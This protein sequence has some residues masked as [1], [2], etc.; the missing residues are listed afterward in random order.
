MIAMQKQLPLNVLHTFDNESMAQSWLF[1]HGLV[2]VIGD[3]VLDVFGARYAFAGI[4]RGDDTEDNVTAEIVLAGNLPVHEIEEGNARIVGAAGV[5]TVEA[6]EPAPRL[7]SDDYAAMHAYENGHQKSLPAIIIQTDMNEV[8][9]TLQKMQ[10]QLLALGNMIGQLV[11]M[12]GA[13]I[14]ILQERQQ[15]NV[16]VEAPEVILNPTFQ[17]PEQEVIVNA[18]VR[19]PDEEKT[20]LVKAGTGYQ[21]VKER[22]Y[23]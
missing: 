1:S 2:P 23:N 22:V 15:V 21:V 6:D 14:G 8:A 10:E 9:V 13:I 12:Q 16:T 19:L 20:T 17:V 5:L 11:A 18:I 4:L 7:S 3:S